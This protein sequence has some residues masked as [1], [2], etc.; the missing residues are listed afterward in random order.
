MY[1][2]NGHPK[3]VSIKGIKINDQLLVEKKSL[4]I[5]STITIRLLNFHGHYST[6]RK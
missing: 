2:K 4:E 6:K 1:K 3:L 5:V